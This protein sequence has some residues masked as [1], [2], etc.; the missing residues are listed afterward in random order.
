MKKSALAQRFLKLS[1]LFV[2]TSLLILTPGCCKR[3]TN[4][5]DA[6]LI[7]VRNDYRT[8]TKFK[9]TQNTPHSVTLQ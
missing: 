2:A 4:P 3:Y 9:R 5:D 1:A 7:A 6:P 8:V